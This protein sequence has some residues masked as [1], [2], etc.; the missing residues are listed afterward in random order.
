MKPDS[1]QITAIEDPSLPL[2]QRRGL[3]M[4]IGSTVREFGHSTGLLYAV[5]PLFRVC[6]RI[7]G[8]SPTT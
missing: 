4:R 7:V 3:R 5:D 1:P 6:L 2:V 8:C